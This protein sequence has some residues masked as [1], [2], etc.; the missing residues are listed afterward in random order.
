MQRQIAGMNLSTIIS[1]KLQSDESSDQPLPKDSYTS[2]TKIKVQRMN[3]AS[4]PRFIFF[5]EIKNDITL[6]VLREIYSDHDT[7][8]RKFNN[9]KDKN[10][11]MSWHE[12]SED[13]RQE[14]TKAFEE[15]KEKESKDILPD[16]FRKYED[17][18]RRFDEASRSKDIIIYEMQEWV[19]GYTDVEEI[20]KKSLFDLLVN[21]VVD[22]TF[23]HTKF[24]KDGFY[25]VNVEGYK[26]AIR[27]DYSSGKLNNI[28]LLQVS[29]SINTEDL[30]EH[31]YGCADISS[32]KR[33]AAKC[34][35][36]FILLDFK[37]WVA[38][39]DDS[40]A[41]LA[42]SGEELK[43]LQD[44]EYPF[45]VSG[46]AGSGKSTIL[47]Y[48]YAHIYDYE[49]RHFPGHKLLFLSYSKKLV[50]NAQSIVKSILCHHPAYN[51]ENIFEDKDKSRQ[52]DM[53]FQPFQDFIKGE[54]LSMDELEIYPHKKYI[55]YQRFKQLYATCK[56][57][58]CKNYSPDIVWSVIRTFIKGRLNDR[59]FT[60]QDY[61]SNTL[62]AKDRTVTKEDYKAIYKIWENWYKKYYEQRTGWDDLDL[63]R[64]AFSKRVNDSRFH[65]YAVIFCDEAQDFTKIETDFILKLSVH[66]KYNLTTRKEDAQIPIAFAGDPNQTINPTGFRWGSTQEIFNDSFQDCLATFSGF[67]PNELRLN[68]RSREGIVKFANTIQCIR[69]RIL[70]DGK[71]HFVL[72]EAWDSELS[73]G[74]NESDGLNYVAFYSINQHREQ[75]IK[76]FQ[77]AIIITAA[78]GEYS[79]EN[80]PDDPILKDVDSSKIYTAIT[81]KGLEFKATILYKFGADPAVLLFDKL[82]DGGQIDGDSERYQLSHFF[83]KLYIAISRA[84]QVLFIVDTDSGYDKLWKHFVDKSLWDNFLKTY[85]S[86]DINYVGRIS[87]G[88][89]FDFEHRLAENYKPKEY[90]ESLFKNAMDE[91]DA[92][93]MNRARSAYKEAK[94]EK[95]AELCQAFIYKFNKEF[96]KAGEKFLEQGQKEYAIEAYWEGCAWDEVISLL[97]N[98]PKEYDGKTFKKAVAQFMSPKTASSLQE[99]LKIWRENEDEFQDSLANSKDR[100]LWN[101]IVRQISTKANG[102]QAKDIT[103]SLIR[104]L[105]RLSAYLDWYEY[106]IARLRAE[107]HFRRAEFANRGIAE[108]DSDFKKI[109][110]AAAVKW[111]ETLPGKLTSKDYYKAK[112]ILSSTPSEKIIWMEKLGETKEIISNYGSAETAKT[113]TDEAQEKVFNCLLDTDLTLALN[114][115][116]PQNSDNKLNRLYMRDRVNFLRMII[117][118]DFTQEKFDFLQNKVSEDESNAFQSRV[119]E[120]VIDSIFSLKGEDKDKIPY[121]SYFVSDLRNNLDEQVMRNNIN[122][123]TVLTSIEKQLMPSDKINK[124]L[125]TCFLDML[126]DG[127]Y[128]FGR[129]KKHLSTLAQLFRH[130]LFFKEDFRIST[131]R[132]AYFSQ[133]CK[134]SPEDVNRIKGNMHKFAHEYLSNINKK[135]N[136]MAMNDTIKPL[137]MM[138]EIS[139][140]YRNINSETN[141]I[142]SYAPD[143]SNICNEYKRFLTDKELKKNFEI[144]STWMSQR[145]LFNKYLESYQQEKSSYEQ[146]RQSFSEEKFDL[147]HFVL[148]LS[149]EDSIAYIIAAHLGGGEYNFAGTLL[150]ARTLYIKRLKT[151]DFRPYCNTNILKEAITNSADWAI[152]ELLA[153]RSYVNEYE[154]KLLTFT[155]EALGDHI[156]A[157]NKYDDLIDR[158]RLEKL[159]RLKNYFKRRALLH[160]A[161]WTQKD[162]ESKQAEYGITMA[163]DNLPS[164]YPRI[165]KEGESQPQTQTPVPP[166]GVI[167]PDETE[168]TIDPVKTAMLEMARKMKNSG[169]D[170]KQI[171][172]FTNL[173]ETE[174]RRA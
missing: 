92:E 130:D 69:H 18:P 84:K 173:S 15:L 99:F 71:Q 116:Y 85:L 35:P 146:I 154:L 25:V 134:S 55:D 109:E 100:D 21:L 121:W 44:I 118:K 156:S 36:D 129:G 166:I 30:K 168:T 29:E 51:L 98:D 80:N 93:T 115:P 128:N 91:E 108:N 75:I 39:E 32:L 9:I 41:N 140:P 123:E 101:A 49:T 48:L 86:S 133:Y 56:L 145:Y 102:L 171:M 27:L 83:T 158:K 127:D 2:S 54:F 159:T 62:S 88:D 89:I 64:Y 114:Y 169:M 162:F 45:F 163:L 96:C 4:G 57:P 53:S 52:F 147:E 59:Y 70:S 106:G 172:A 10:I 47:Y 33:K 7:Y 42:L 13:E 119:P 78:E 174:V 135:V 165:E 155:W 34:Y 131:K 3:I 142:A 11:W 73:G 58:E 65:K 148:S 151:N 60:P 20:C 22:K 12:Y 66:S 79:M 170:I 76:G 164:M 6:Y 149:K 81:A 63:V 122:R 144:P 137:F 103:S 40:Q 1:E 105:D 113:L 82:M 16:E 160:Y 111:W 72:Q 167:V 19:N 5:E 136:A 139:A 125:A 112:K 110:Y 95:K 50:T 143:Y 161:H 77:K 97:Q 46:L 153:S 87:R 23:D 138:Y 157:A 132:N 24:D 90:A 8:L 104:D 150:T 26:V 74:K 107:L 117:L 43:T 38:I 17:W 68:Y 61:D 152:K 94:Y 28:Y 126:F 120:D 67:K 31:G 141:P 124:A 37:S 14:I